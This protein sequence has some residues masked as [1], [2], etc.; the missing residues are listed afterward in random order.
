MIDSIKLDI[1][2]AEV[3]AELNVVETER[4]RAAGFTHTPDKVTSKNRSK[5]VAI[6][7]GSSGAFLVEK[8]TGELYN[9]KG[10]GVADYNKKLKA[11][12]GNLF[13]VDVRKLWSQRWNYLR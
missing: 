8:S 11:N 4:F 1:R 2:L 9:I 12:I 10:Y 6:D 7:F 3:V 5:F 13:T